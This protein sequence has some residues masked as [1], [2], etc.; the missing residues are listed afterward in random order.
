MTASATSFLPT[1]LPLDPPIDMETW[2]NGSIDLLCDPAIHKYECRCVGRLIAVS[3]EQSDELLMN[4]IGL[5]PY[6]LTD[7]FR[8]TRLAFDVPTGARAAT[9]IIAGVQRVIDAI[10]PNR[11]IA[12]PAGGVA[13]LWRMIEVIRAAS[14]AYRDGQL[15]KL[16]ED[17]SHPAFLCIAVAI[18][19]RFGILPTDQWRLP[20]DFESLELA[21]IGAV[22]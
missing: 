20:A 21:R 10:G 11:L 4:E 22:N 1:E 15:E 17:L 9:G 13:V 12:T 6:R 3:W 19:V 2:R 14:R 8:R 5:P 16:A 18:N 7:E